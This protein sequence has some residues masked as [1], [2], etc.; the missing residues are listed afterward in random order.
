[1]INRMF[2]GNCGSEE[3]SQRET[4]AAILIAL[5]RVLERGD[6]QQ[7]KTDGTWGKVKEVKKQLKTKSKK[8]SKF[9]SNQP[10]KVFCRDP[11]RRT[12]SFA[13]KI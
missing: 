1:M 11:A 12:I 13:I 6:H 3:C 8:I 9:H 5:M 2:D 7:M 4:W 10:E